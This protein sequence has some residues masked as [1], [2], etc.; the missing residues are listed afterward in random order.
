[1]ASDKDSLDV[2]NLRF[3]HHLKMLS[4]NKELVRKRRAEMIKEE[5][6]NSKMQSRVGGDSPANRSY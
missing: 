6:S 4:H 3:E 1:M 2:I 5:K